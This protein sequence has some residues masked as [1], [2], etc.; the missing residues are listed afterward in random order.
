MAEITTYKYRVE[1]QDVDFTLRASVGSIINYMLNVAGLDA[2]NKGFG[3]EV[4]QGNS[5]TWVLSR[6][7]IEVKRQP[8]QYAYIEVDTWVNEFN[9]LTTTRNFRL[10][11]GEEMHAEGVSQWC[12]IDMASR[13]AVDLNIFKDIYCRALVDEASPIAAPARLRGITPTATMSRPVVYSDLDFNRHMNTLRYVDL[14]FDAMPLEL[15]EKNRGMRLD[16]H[17]LAEALYGDTLT[18]GY[19]SEGDVW[20]FEISANGEKTLCRARIELTM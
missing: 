12:V 19:V 6:L 4:L 14:I 9:R 17:F 10:H 2:H 11:V 18:V 15:I 1:P 8:E 5:F 20:Q 7:A 3:V 16:I 13:Q